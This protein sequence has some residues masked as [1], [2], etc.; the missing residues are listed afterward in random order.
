[1]EVTENSILTQLE[2]VYFKKSNE[3]R[4]F[5][6]IFLKV[7]DKLRS[8]VILGKPNQSLANNL[9]QIFSDKSNTK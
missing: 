2:T 9:N 7:L 6:F 3:V 8:T 1:V 4:L 5:F